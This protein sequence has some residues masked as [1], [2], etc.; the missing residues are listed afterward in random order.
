LARSGDQAL[1]GFL[2]G[3]I[4]LMFESNG[5]WYVADYKSNRLPTYEP[6]TVLEAVQ[7]DHYVLQGL[8]Y[9]AAAN[10]FLRQRL[11]NYE[12]EEHW[13][14]TLFLFLRG[15]QGPEKAGESVYFD[16]QSPELIDA[17]D[18]WLGG[19]DESA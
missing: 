10:R 13:G 18:R 16:R 17:L 8:L 11:P 19:V 7:R 2:R 9:A 3:F 12:P 15:M 6:A 4:D 1:Q 5:C 14:G